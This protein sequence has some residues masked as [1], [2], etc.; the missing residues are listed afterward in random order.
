MIPVKKYI[1]NQFIGKTFHFKCDCII[2]IDV[3]GTVCDYDI[4]SQEV[5]LL[6][7]SNGKILHIGLNSPSLVIDEI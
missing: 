5:I 6:I 1:A 2:P 7:N 4:S 3:I